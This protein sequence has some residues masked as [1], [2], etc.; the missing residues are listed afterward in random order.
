MEAPCRNLARE[1]FCGQAADLQLEV[2]HR[3]LAKKNLSSSFCLTVPKQIVKQ[4]I[5][6]YLGQ[7]NFP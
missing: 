3:N 4:K 5:L 1:N 6:L 2:F 7:N